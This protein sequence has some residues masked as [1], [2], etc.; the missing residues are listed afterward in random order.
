MVATASAGA[1]AV[2]GT[3]LATA[4]EAQQHVS[5]LDPNTVI[6]IPTPPDLS[7]AVAQAQASADE[8]QGSANQASASAEAAQT[9]ANT[10][11]S[12]ADEAQET[13]DQAIDAIPKLIADDSVTT[14][15]FAVA[16][17]GTVSL[18][19]GTYLIHYGYD[20]QHAHTNIKISFSDGRVIERGFSEQGNSKFWDSRAIITVGPNVTATLQV[21]T[22]ASSPEESH[23]FDSVFALFSKVN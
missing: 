20:P 16:D 7:D 10:A 19:E 13:A 17:V 18:S 2:A 22:F 3:A 11:Q 15:D 4:Q 9:S 12:A 6:T 8:A 14:I 5:Q 1:I 21:H 23:T